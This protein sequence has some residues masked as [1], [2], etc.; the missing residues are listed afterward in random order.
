MRTSLIEHGADVNQAC[1]K[2][3]STPLHRAVTQTGGPGTAGKAE[4]AKE[5]YSNSPGRR[6]IAFDP[7]QVR[8][9]PVAY[10]KNTRGER[11]W[12]ERRQDL[13]EAAVFLSC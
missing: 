11:R 8:K 13:R 1:G 10:I 9:R 3:G 4:Q 2:S 6:R 12:T 7:Q 5:N